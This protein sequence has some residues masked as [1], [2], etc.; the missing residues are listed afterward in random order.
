MSLTSKLF[1][2]SNEEI[3][4]EISHL[5]FDPFRPI[6]IF[7]IEMCTTILEFKMGN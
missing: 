6:R 7:G 5:G 1:S 2:Y 4:Y 3:G